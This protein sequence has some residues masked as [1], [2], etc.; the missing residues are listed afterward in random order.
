MKHLNIFKGKSVFITGHTGFKGAWLAF[1][2]N[3]LGAKVT[4]YALDPAYSNSLF[5]VLDLAADITSIKGD[6][7]DY[8]SLHQA[9]QQ[10]NPEFVFHLA[11]QSLVRKSYEEP[12]LTY[13]TNVMGS[14]NI[15]ESVRH[16]PTV[17]ALVY[18]TSDK[19]YWNKEWAWGYRENDELGGTDPYSS[20]KA[21]AELLFK[22][23]YLSYFKNRDNFGCG[24]TRAGNVIGGG[25]RSCNRIVPDVIE[26]LEKEQTIILRNP[27][28]TRPWQFVLDP[29]YGYLKLAAEL[30]VDP[31]R[32][33]GEAWNFG[34]RE[35]SIR[36]V[37]DVAETLVKVWGSGKIQVEKNPHAPHEASLLHLSIDKA[38]Q[39]LNWQPTYDFYTT[40]KQTGEWYKKSYHGENVKEITSKQLKDFMELLND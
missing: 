14:L 15:L 29:L 22:T 9:M 37:K 25:D 13:S 20:S 23:Y 26:A 31:Q 34:P 33:N 17:R 40:I 12:Q 1:W 3:K 18:I 35:Q 16:Y 7:R 21:C 30:Y 38:G 19:C 32:I 8:N 4:G 36:T 10:A 24:S 27:D 28:A 5:E 2:L 6:I 39:G 11:A